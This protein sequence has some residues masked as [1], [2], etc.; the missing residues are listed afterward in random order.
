MKVWA[1]SVTLSKSENGVAV[2]DRRIRSY[3]FSVESRFYGSW[4]IQ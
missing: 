4:E 3:V 1:D 2:V